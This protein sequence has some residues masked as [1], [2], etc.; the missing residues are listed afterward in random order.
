MQIFFGLLLLI[1]LTLSQARELQWTGS[2]SSD[3]A[4]ATNWDPNFVPTASDDVKIEKIDGTSFT[5]EPNLHTMYATCTNLHLAAGNTLS[6]EKTSSLIVLGNL[7]VDGTFVMG[8]DDNEFSSLIVGGSATGNV[9][10]NRYIHYGD[11][12]GFPVGP[13]GIQSF[14]TANS[15]LIKRTGPDYSFSRYDNQ[16]EHGNGDFT[17]VSTSSS[18]LATP[19][20][21]YAIST[22]SSS[23]GVIAFTGS[24]HSTNLNVAIK[25]TADRIWNFVSNPYPSYINGKKFLLQNSDKIHDE[26]EAVYMWNGIKFEAYNGILDFSIAPGQGFWIASDSTD[27]E[28]ITF[29]TDMRTIDGDDDAIV[30]DGGSEGGD[31]ERVPFD[32][33]CT[34]FS[35]TNYDS[36]ATVDDNS[37]TYSTYRTC[38]DIAGDNSNTAFDCDTAANDIAAMP[39][40]ITC[41]S[42]T[43][44]CTP[45]E[46]CTAVPM[47]VDECLV[48]LEFLSCAALKACNTLRCANSCGKG[49]LIT[50]CRAYAAQWTSSC[51]CQ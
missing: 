45:T 9:I 33:G 44:G 3:W 14:I 46:C 24:V 51:A 18:G 39:A 26:Y 22:S 16:Y 32:A 42:Q 6:L 4:N 20:N 1:T 15:G 43:D 23:G 2:T 47:M 11:Q 29:T 31:S 36:T 30:A 37:C 38:A 40:G 17:Q 49:S 35:A 28:E 21:G 41:S 48:N 25:K 50:L 27:T 19:G 7:A 10:Y 5:N 13:I 34:D 12:I 8:S